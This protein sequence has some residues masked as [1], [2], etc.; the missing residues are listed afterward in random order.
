ML[1]V[2][3]TEE[4]N[5]NVGVPDKVGVSVRDTEMSID[6][7]T[8]GVGG[9][10]AIEVDAVDVLVTMLDTEGARDEDTVATGVFEGL[11]PEESHHDAA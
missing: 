8:D 2:T 5:V 3:L 11:T 10:G 6:V 1:G 9:V 4:V 7:D